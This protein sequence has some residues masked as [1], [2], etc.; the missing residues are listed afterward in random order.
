MARSDSTAEW[1]AAAN[2]MMP[3]LHAPAGVYQCDDSGQQAAARALW[4]DADGASFA[5]ESSGG[6][7]LGGYVVGDDLGDEYWLRVFGLNRPAAAR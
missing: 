2:T 7:S 3:W 1:S 4:N 6:G 5:P